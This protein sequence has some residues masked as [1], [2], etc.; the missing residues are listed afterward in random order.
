[1][2]KIAMVEKEG[3]DLSELLPLISGERA[4]QVWKD[5]NA[6]MAMLT[7]GQSIGRINDIPTVTELIQRMIKEAQETLQNSM[8]AFAD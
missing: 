5:G 4:R 2:N 6:E 8:H 3:G 1:M 7:I